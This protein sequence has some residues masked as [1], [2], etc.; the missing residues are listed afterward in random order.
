LSSEMS[1]EVS[2]RRP[3]VPQTWKS[4]QYEHVLRLDILGSTNQEIADALGY[5]KGQIKRIKAMPQYKDL[6]AKILEGE[7]GDLLKRTEAQ[8]ATLL[9]TA[10]ETYEKVMNDS[11]AHNRDKISAADSVTDRFLPKRSRAQIDAH[12]KAE[13]FTI[14]VDNRPE[15]VMAEMGDDALRHCPKCGRQYVLGSGHPCLSDEEHDAE[16]KEVLL[17]TPGRAALP[18]ADYEIVNNDSSD[19]TVE[20]AEPE[21]CELCGKELS[22]F[23][24]CNV[25]ELPPERQAEAL[26]RGGWKVSSESW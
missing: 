7:H 22:E 19:D 5:S 17:Y 21:V 23:H 2:G 10:I 20:D 13:T 4:P 25:F 26:R 14:H 12:V 15:S 18:E 1:T 9:P 11:E 24:R 3:D 8:L 16:L 6:K